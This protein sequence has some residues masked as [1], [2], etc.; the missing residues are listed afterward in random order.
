MAV[1]FGALL[2]DAIVTAID[3]NGPWDPVITV[4][5][6]YTPEVDLATMT[7]A[8]TLVVKFSSDSATETATSKHTRGK[9][10]IDITYDLLLSKKA[11]RGDEASLDAVVGLYE[12]ID[13]Y[14]FEFHRNITFAGGEANWIS[15]LFLMPGDNDDLRTHGVCEVIGSVTYRY[16]R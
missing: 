7:S 10:F 9:R 16:E 13:Q 3:G 4:T 15:S 1:S 2:G 14:L 5:R 12:L 11:Q 8:A 6:E